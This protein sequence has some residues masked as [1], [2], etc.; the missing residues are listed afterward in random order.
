MTVISNTTE[1][2][3]TPGEVAELLRAL[4]E[5]YWEGLIDEKWPVFLWGEPG[6]GKTAVTRQ[7]AASLDV[8]HI[9]CRLSQMARVDIL[10][11]P[12]VTKEGR[13]RWNP[14]IILPSGGRSFLVLDE[15]SMADE[16][17]QKASL[18]LLFERQAGEYRLPGECFV[19][20]CGNRQEDGAGVKKVIEPAV[21]RCVNINVRASIKDWTDWALKRGLHGDV[22]AFL[23]FKPDAFCTPPERTGPV[24]RG[25]PCP[26]TWHMVSDL[27]KSKIEAGPGGMLHKAV[28]GAVGRE[29]GHEFI[30]FQEICGQIPPVQD[31][32]R[33]ADSFE[34]P[35]EPDILWAMIGSVAEFCRG[36]DVKVLARAMILVERMSKEFGV[37]LFKSLAGANRAIVKV[38]AARPWLAN[39]SEALSD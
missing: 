1:M 5:S 3:M 9:D 36:K 4:A 37:F 33:R 34:Q 19:L 13:T 14:P 23:Q 39:L 12:S 28:C 31:I 26:R 38:P 25:R 10:G 15:F 24:K 16:D 6:I 17:T 21:S 8:I 29:Y 18:Q 11:V 27:C 30:G 22:I 20:L 7:A 35:E 2:T 32:L